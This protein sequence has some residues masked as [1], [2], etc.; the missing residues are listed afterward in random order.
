MA[1]LTSCVT[2]PVLWLLLSSLLAC[3]LMVFVTAVFVLSIARF[4]VFV[5]ILVSTSRFLP[6]E[7]FVLLGHVPAMHEINDFL[8]GTLGQCVVF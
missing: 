2:S 6:L 8:H 3:A 1:F 7:H 5:L 4:T